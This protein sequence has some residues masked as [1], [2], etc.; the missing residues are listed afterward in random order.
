[1]VDICCEEVKFRSGER[2]TIL[3][4]SEGSRGCWA[5]GMEKTIGTTENI[6]Y[7]Q[8]DGIKIFY[9]LSNGYFYHEDDLEA[10][11]EWSKVNILG[12]CDK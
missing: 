12:V 10:V 6:T 1:M 2:V 7:I 8:I 11:R 5:V 3:R 4:N 9:L